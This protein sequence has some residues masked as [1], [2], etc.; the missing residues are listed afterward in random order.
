[1]AAA[2]AI[3][4]PVFPVVTVAQAQPGEVSDGNAQDGPIMLM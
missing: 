2:P 4:A 1:M 3:L